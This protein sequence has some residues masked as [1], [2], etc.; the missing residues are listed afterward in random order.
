MILLPSHPIPQV[1]SVGFGEGG[2]ELKGLSP[3]PAPPFPP[4]ARVPAPT[5][6]RCMTRPPHA[7]RTPPALRERTD[8]GQGAGRLG[9]NEW[10]GGFPEL[11]GSPSPTHTHTAISFSHSN[12]GGA[13]LA[14]RWWGEWRGGALRDGGGVRRQCGEGR[15]ANRPTLVLMAGLLSPPAGQGGRG[16]H[17]PFPKPPPRPPWVH[18][19]PNAEAAAC[20]PPLPK[21]KVSCPLPTHPHSP[22]K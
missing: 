21:E 3:S 10:R 17:G 9:R 5:R 16:R 1:N 2:S 6:M 8:T 11:R 13:G 15:S 4:A 18:E 12:V 20:H 19:P 22:P 7:C 14:C